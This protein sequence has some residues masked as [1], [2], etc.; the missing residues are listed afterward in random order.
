M[1]SAAWSGGCDTRCSAR[2]TMIQSP[3]WL[4]SGPRARAC[5]A[6][7]LA[8]PCLTAGRP[9]NAAQTARRVPAVDQAARPSPTDPH[10]GARGA[11]ASLGA[12][13][14]R[15]LPAAARRAGRGHPSVPTRF[16][17]RLWVRWAVRSCGVH[18]IR[19]AHP[20]T[21]APSELEFAPPVPGRR[22]QLTL[23]LDAVGNLV[24]LDVRGLHDA[25]ARGVAIVG[26]EVFGHAAVE[27]RARARPSRLRAHDAAC[28]RARAGS[29]RAAGALLP[30][31][32]DLRVGPRGQRG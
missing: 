27:V 23:H 3:A 7:P 17:P 1:T 24:R 15:R 18:P 9:R 13:L 19:A 6:P 20:G 11:C 10:H 2:P 5:L 14:G 12:C 29:A 16:L 31:G 4:P 21:P 28:A 22:Q 26:I 8:C 30:S 32:R 25:Q